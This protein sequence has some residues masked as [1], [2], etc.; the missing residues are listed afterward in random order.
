MWVGRC[1]TGACVPRPDRGVEQRVGCGAAQVLY[2]HIFGVLLGEH[3]TVWGVLGAALIACGVVSVNRAKSGL[4][5][6]G[7]PAVSHAKGPSLA[8]RGHI[9]YAPLTWQGSHGEAAVPAHHPAATDEASED[10]GSIAALRHE[11]QVPGWTSPSGTVR[12]T[13]SSMGDKRCSRSSG[14]PC[15]SSSSPQ[16]VGLELQERSLS[17]V[18]EGPL[19]PSSSVA[20]LLAAGQP[21]E[22]EAAQETSV[23]LEAGSAQP[24]T[25]HIAQPARGLSRQ[26]RTGVSGGQTLRD[27][28]RSWTGEWVFKGKQ[29]LWEPNTAARNSQIREQDS[30]LSAGRE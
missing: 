23:P 25:R 16:R 20:N 5:D 22:R 30:L 7:L 15:S 6:V 13:G 1:P 12:L 4:P 8:E 18:D 26:A 3:E 21:A 17:A 10:A 11:R 24:P 9:L 27:R 2:A 28:E 19:A 14:A 29:A